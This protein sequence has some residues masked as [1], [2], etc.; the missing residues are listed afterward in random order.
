MPNAPEAQVF[1]AV[2]AFNAV[3]EHA[4]CGGGGCFGGDFWMKKNK[5]TG[6]RFSIHPIAAVVWV[7]LLVVLGPL[8]AFAYVL[9][10]LL[11][12]FGH[13]FA[14]KARGYALS[15]FSFSPYG[16]SLSYFGQTLESADEIF[17]AL[18]GP[19]ANLATSLLVVALWWIWPVSYF[20]TAQFV[21]ISVALALVNLLPAFPLDG[22]RVFVCACKDIFSQN[23]A[24]KIAVAANLAF[25]TLFLALFVGMCFV[26]FNPTL[27]L[28]AFFMFAGVLDLNFE[29]KYQKINVFCKKTKAF[30]HVCVL[31]VQENVSI[32]KL[33][34][35]MQTNKTVMFCLTLE[36]GK[37]FF[38]SEKLVQK[39]AISFP[40][41]TR[42]CDI[43]SGAE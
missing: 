21:E 1:G 7:W 27:F 3:C 10:I 18:A 2:F 29:S 30:S 41:E 13:F 34:S 8:C 39:L 9:A 20:F 32:K 35:K 6:R 22:G 40:P 25:G 37:T 14:A 43:V 31:A 24:R 36:S 28:F 42:L 11:H 26:N 4:C 12:E 38:L 16:V 33:L 17:I 15:R 19:V 23:T 5:N